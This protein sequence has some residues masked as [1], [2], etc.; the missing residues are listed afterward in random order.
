[1]D[2]EAEI[3]ELKKRVAAL[4]EQVRLLMSAHPRPKIAVTVAAE[5]RWNGGPILPLGLALKKCDDGKYVPAGEGELI[6]GTLANT[7]RV[8]DFN[9]NYTDKMAAMELCYQ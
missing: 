3:D 6:A 5:S 9:G 2:Y 4:Q 7:I 1:M 8:A